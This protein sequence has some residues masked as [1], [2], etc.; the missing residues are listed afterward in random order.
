[1]EHAFDYN[2]FM[3]FT[4]L[5]ASAGSNHNVFKYAMDYLAALSMLPLMSIAHFDS[6]VIEL[7]KPIWNEEVKKW[8][9]LPGFVALQLLCGHLSL[10]SKSLTPACSVV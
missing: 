3:S 8:L 10:H 6:T 7:V 4:Q 1:M 2:F 9:K 5:K